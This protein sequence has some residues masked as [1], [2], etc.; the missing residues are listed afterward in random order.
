MKS[1]YSLTPDELAELVAAVFQSNGHSV[2]NLAIRKNGEL[3]DW[4][5]AT[6]EASGFPLKVRCEPENSLADILKKRQEQ[7]LQSA[8]FPGQQDQEPQQDQQGT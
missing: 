5:S 3:V 8:F 7:L 6:V 4:D 1:V 2:T